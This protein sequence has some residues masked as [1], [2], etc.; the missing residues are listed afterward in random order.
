MNGWCP[1]SN[2]KGDTAKYRCVVTEL[3]EGDIRCDCG[4]RLKKSNVGFG[5]GWSIPRHKKG[6]RK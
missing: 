4:K 5:Y 2:M 1:W 3:P 6:D